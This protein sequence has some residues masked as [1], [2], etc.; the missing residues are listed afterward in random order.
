MR[1]IPFDSHQHSAQIGNLGYVDE[2]LYFGQYTRSPAIV[3]QSCNPAEMD[4]LQRSQTWGLPAYY[5]I[6]SCDNG[7]GHEVW[8]WPVPDGVGGTVVI[9]GS[10]H[11]DAGERP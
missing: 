4:A 1:A 9:S 8:I 3:L 10:F 5:N 11:S 2:V 6:R 7:D